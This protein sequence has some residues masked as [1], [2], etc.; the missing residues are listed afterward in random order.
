MPSKRRMNH[1]LPNS[2]PVVCSVESAISYPKNRMHAIVK[3]EE[4]SLM[5]WETLIEF[6]SKINA[7]SYISM[8]QQGFLTFLFTLW[9]GH[10]HY[11]FHAK[12]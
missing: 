5:I 12:Q 4:Y 7:A 3:Q 6:F 2:L 9:N 11:I 1:S 10:E 8:F